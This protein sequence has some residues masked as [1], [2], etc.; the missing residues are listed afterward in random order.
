M[1]QRSLRKAIVIVQA[2]NDGFQNVEIE[3]MELRK[4]K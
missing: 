3:R 4:Q 1:K 2:A